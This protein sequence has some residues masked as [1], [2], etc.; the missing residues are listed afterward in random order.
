MPP[1]ISNSEVAAAVHKHRTSIGL[2]GFNGCDSNGKSLGHSRL[3]FSNEENQ[4]H[5]YAAGALEECGLKTWSDAFGNLHGRLGD[6]GGKAIMI[7]T[8][9][10]TVENGGNYDGVV[11]FIV[12]IEAVRLAA[13]RGTLRD[14]VE[15]VVFRAEES[16]KFKKSCLGSRAG[17]GRLSPNELQTLQ[18]KGTPLGDD[19]KRCGGDPLAIGRPLIDAGKFHAYFETHIEQAR[20]LDGQ[21]NLG[22][23]TSIRAPERRQ[24]TVGHKAGLPCPDVVRAVARMITAIEWTAELFDGFGDDIVGTVGKVDD[25]F[26]GARQVNT[27]PGCVEFEVREWSESDERVARAVTNARRLETPIVIRRAGNVRIAVTGTPDHSG[28]TPMGRLNRRDGL[29]AACDILRSLPIERIPELPLIRFYLDLRSRSKATRNRVSARIIDTLQLIADGCGV[30]LEVEEP[31]EQGDPVK[32]LDPVLQDHLRNACRT[33]EIAFTDLPSGAG[34]D[35]MI[36]AQAGIP[37]A[38]LFVPCDAGLSHNPSEH[39]EDKY[40]CW[41][42]EVQAEALRSLSG[43]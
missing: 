7:G 30:E 14:P 26:I 1:S 10:D 8:H 5:A 4:V 19:L 25:Y 39:T 12:A 33:L 31:T 38:M 16:T 36:A 15:I 42:V 18:F 17:F 41:A 32:S 21:E 3:A 27:I 29:V 22:I 20:V 24:F 9:L 2:I 35:A 34:H 13:A 23:V 6:T 40:I 43:G 11:G 37:T 28:G